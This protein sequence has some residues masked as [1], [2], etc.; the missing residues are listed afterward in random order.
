[1][2]LVS[3]PLPELL[4]IM[5]SNLRGAADIP[6]RVVMAGNPGGPGHFWLAKRYVF[7]S[8]AWKP[9]EETKSKRTWMYCPSTLMGNEFIDRDQYRDQLEGACPDDPELLRA[10]LEGD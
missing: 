8:G 9:F 2:R 7:T 6:I 1:M 3:G 5:R 4:D 10:W